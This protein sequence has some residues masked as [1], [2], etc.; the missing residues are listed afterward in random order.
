MWSQLEV[1]QLLEQ[2]QD[3]QLH[4]QHTLKLCEEEKRQIF[5]DKLIMSLGVAWR[6]T[7]KDCFL[8]N[9]HVYMYLYMCDI[10]IYTLY[11]HMHTYVYIYMCVCV[12]M[13]M[14]TI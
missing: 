2:C 3:R 8:M 6:N 12:C 1:D 7:W 11:Q 14:Y 5:L 4:V 9:Q 13:H 10:C